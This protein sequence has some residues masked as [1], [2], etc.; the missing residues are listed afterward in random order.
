M[1]ILL[2]TR[3]QPPELFTPLLRDALPAVEIF[4]SGAEL[5]SAQADGVEAIIAWW[6]KPGTCGRYPRLKLV[7]ATAAGVEKLISDPSLRNDVAVM[8]IV[9]PMVNLGIAQY[10]VLMALRHSRTL[11]LYV[12]QQRRHDWTRHRAVE[13]YAMTVGILGLGAAGQASARLLHAA[14]FKVVGWSRTSRSVADVESFAGLDQ[15]EACLGR[16]DI[17]V[18]TLPLTDAT[19]GLIDH[20][21]LAQ[22]PRGAYVI[23]VARGAHVVEADL[24]AAIDAG[25]LSGAALDVQ[26][27]EP[28][29]ADS[30]L[31]DHPRIIVTPHIAAQASI[32]SVVDQFVANWR[33]LESGESMTN[34]I[35]RG[36]GY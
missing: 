29:P 5:T 21:R 28:L 32:A 11:P 15:L 23:N 3:P 6:L 13:P 26:R 7:C 9:D 20:M 10:V 2:L 25:H 1:S 8:R 27:T 35:D 4:H 19:R 34:I 14:G 18:C 12:E 31:W 30:P 33:R 36:L 22:L 16:A 17:L 24:A